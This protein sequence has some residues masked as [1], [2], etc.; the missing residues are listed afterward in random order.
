MSTEHTVKDG[1]CIENIA[2]R[3]GFFADT[4]WNHPDNRA[5]HD[6][7]KDPNILLPGDVVNIPQLRQK[8]YPGGTEQRHRFRRKGVPARLRVKFLRPVTPKPQEAGG[9]EGGKY[10]PSEYQ[11]PTR[12]ADEKHEPIANAPFKLRVDGRNTD[13]QSDANGMIDVPIPNDAAS[14][15]ITFNPGTKDEVSYDLALGEMAPI[16]TVIGVR[17]RLYNLG[18]RCMPSG[19]QVD[20]PLKDALRRFQTDQALT[21]T[22]AIDQATKDKLKNIHGS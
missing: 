9:A 12:K 13:G 15:K 17:K 18:Y 22:G 4:L 3:Y 11:E 8:D 2:K 14:G 19:D 10:N 16:D 21:A 20:E 7:R 1:D 6:L 5:L